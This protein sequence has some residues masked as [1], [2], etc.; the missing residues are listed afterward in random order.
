VTRHEWRARSSTAPSTAA[1]WSLSF[2]GLQPYWGLGGSVGLAESAGAALADERPGWFAAV[3]LY[4][5]AL[6]FGA[7]P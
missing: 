1:G 7:A 3:G 4:G 2:A 5:A 6:L